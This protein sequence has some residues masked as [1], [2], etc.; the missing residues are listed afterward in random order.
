MLSSQFV[1]YFT[2][3][4]KEQ[5]SPASDTRLLAVGGQE[6]SLLSPFVL[7]VF[8]FPAPPFFLQPVSP[9]FPTGVERT[10]AARQKENHFQAG[11]TQTNRRSC[12]ISRQTIV[13]AGADR[14]GALNTILSIISLTLGVAKACCLSAAMGRLSVKSG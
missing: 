10:T 5:V 8:L 4:V 3:C 14:N 9:V 1:L 6:A 2:F 13:K 12:S 7:F 11:L